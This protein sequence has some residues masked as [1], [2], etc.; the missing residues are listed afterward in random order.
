MN[1]MTSFSGQ[2]WA[3]PTALETPVPALSTRA[4]WTYIG[5]AILFA[6]LLPATSCINSYNLP[7]L[8]QA[9]Q[10]P[11]CRII[12]TATGKVIKRMFSYTDDMIANKFSPFTRPVFGMF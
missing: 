11:V 3:Q 1:Y 12:C 2:D 5:I 10:T 6:V 4:R 8:R 9:Q 7:P